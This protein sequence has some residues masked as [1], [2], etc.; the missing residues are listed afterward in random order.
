[1]D[2]HICQKCWV[3]VSV[4]HEF[5]IYIENLHRSNE[6]IFA[7]SIMD[8]IKPIVDSDSDNWDYE[9]PPVEPDADEKAKRKKGRPR[10]DVATEGEEIE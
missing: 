10:R 9:F 1:M 8:D 7:E 3:K 6:T 4:F 2:G 5:Y